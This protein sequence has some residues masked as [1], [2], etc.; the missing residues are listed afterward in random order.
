MTDP[1]SHSTLVTGW[2]KTQS[3]ATWPQRFRDHPIIGTADG[4][5][6]LRSPRIGGVST[7]DSYMFSVREPCGRMGHLT[8]L[9][10][11]FRSERHQQMG[12]MTHPTGLM[13][14][15]PIVAATQESRRS[16]DPQ[17]QVILAAVGVIMPSLDAWW[18][19]AE[20]RRAQRPGPP[21]IGLRKVVHIR[22]GSCMLFVHADD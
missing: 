8:H 17:N 21:P 4:R 16:S 6:F 9:L 18:I 2:V 10:S 3:A 7:V 5:V 13:F 14:A 22:A 11:P 12:P 15:V 19:A 1:Y 20:T